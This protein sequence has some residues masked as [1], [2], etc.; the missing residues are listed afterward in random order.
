[1][2][3]CS[4]SGCHLMVDGLIVGQVAMCECVNAFLVAGRPLHSSVGMHGPFQRSIESLT[5]VSINS[6]VIGM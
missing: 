3:D 6:S 2:P 5:W 1:M 4:A